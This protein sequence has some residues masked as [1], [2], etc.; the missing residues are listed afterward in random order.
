MSSQQD[1]DINC[2]EFQLFITP[3]DRGVAS[4][5]DST[6]SK[7]EVLYLKHTRSNRLQ[8]RRV[9]QDSL[10]DDLYTEIV[11]WNHSAPWWQQEMSCFWNILHLEVFLLIHWPQP[12]Q[13][14]SN[15]SEDI[16]NEGIR[17]LWLFVKRH[18]NGVALKFIN[19]PWNTK[20]L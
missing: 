4:K 11:R 18:Y 2:L 14:V 10:P 12:C 5:F 17:L 16:D 19:S 6:P 13:T 20:L 15:G 8:T 9:R 7:H 1:G 3:C